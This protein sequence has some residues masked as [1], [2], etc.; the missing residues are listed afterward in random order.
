HPAQISVDGMKIYLDKD[1]SMRLSV[2]DSPYEKEYALYHRVVKGGWNVIDVGANIGYFTHVFSRLVGEKGRVV[3]FEPFPE[4]FALLKKS[5]E[6]NGLKNVSLE[7]LALSDTIGKSTLYLSDKN[8]GDNSLVERKGENGVLIRTTTLD[9]Y[10]KE[11]GITRIDMVKIDTQGAE[12]EVLKGMAAV[13]R[14]FHPAILCE[15]WPPMS[16]KE[17]SLEL[18]SLLSS[19]G[20]TFETE[21]GAKIEDFKKFVDDLCT[22]KL[23]F[24]NVFCTYK[25]KV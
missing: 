8:F 11:K 18:L 19:E 17:K 3:A 21:D 20:Y 1:D 15:I 16:G 9:A 22:S 25:A 2:F 10:A 6:A 24:S 12:Y 23:G 7:P 5:A 4:A 14:N 13:I